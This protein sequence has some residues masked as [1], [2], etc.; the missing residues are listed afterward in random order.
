V[1]GVIQLLNRFLH[2][3]APSWYFGFPRILN[4]L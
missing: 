3:P 1:R 4:R 2:V